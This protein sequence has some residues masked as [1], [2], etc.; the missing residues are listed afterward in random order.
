MGRT[1][2]GQRA[3][4]RSDHRVGLASQLRRRRRRCHLRARQVKKGSFYHFFGSK[5]T[6]GRGARV[7]LDGPQANPGRDLRPRRPGVARL[8]RYFRHVYERQMASARNAAAF[9]GAFTP[10]W[11]PSASSRAPSSVPRCRAFFRSSPATSRGPQR[12][13]RQRRA[14]HPNPAAKARALFA[15]VEGSWARP[16]SQRPRNRKAARANRS[17]ARRGFAPRSVRGRPARRKST[18]PSIT[19][20]G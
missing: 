15:Y 12:R 7:A 4:G 2:T 6:P 18:R 20:C 19:R 17:R 9:S 11:A 5:T 8:R 3:S 10:P 14:R 13:P 1:S 16:H